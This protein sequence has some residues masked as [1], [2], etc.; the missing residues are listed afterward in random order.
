MHEEEKEPSN[1]LLAV[2]RCDSRI[3]IKVANQSSAFECFIDPLESNFDTNIASPAQFFLSREIDDISLAFDLVADGLKVV[4][5]RRLGTGIVKML[6]TNVLKKS[7]MGIFGFLQSLGNTI[8]NDQK[9]FQ[10][11]DEQR[12]KLERDLR[13]WK[14]TA[15]KLEGEWQKE[16]DS[17]LENFFSI[18]KT[19]HEELKQAKLELQRLENRKKAILYDNKV[20]DDEKG[21][22][23]ATLDIPDDH[24]ELL[25]DGDTV[26]RLAAGP[27]RNCSI[28]DR[29]EVAERSEVSP[30]KPNN[31]GVTTV[32]KTWKNEASEPSRGVSAGP[33]D[34]STKMQETAISLAKA[35]NIAGHPIASKNAAGT[36]K[37]ITN[38][39]EPLNR[40]YKGN[41]HHSEPRPQQQNDDDISRLCKKPKIS[42]LVNEEK[43]KQLE[44]FNALLSDDD[45]DDDW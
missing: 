45:G 35:V 19:T 7:R 24:D 3:G 22:T 13:C 21:R 1:A 41:N 33:S 11:F 10:S 43:R 18:Y 2:F 14:D 36:G 9:S 42:A 30:D 5:R 38:A 32:E 29:K 39:I 12:E 4:I 44:H 31:K 17:L 37:E 8:N 26:N 25:Y 6:W 28:N 20:R 34:L 23:K 16:K 40:R 15:E 27:K